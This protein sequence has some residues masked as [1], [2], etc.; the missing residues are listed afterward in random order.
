LSQVLF[1]PSTSLL[2]FGIKHFSLFGF[3]HFYSVVGAYALKIFSPMFRLWFSL[4]D[5]A[6]LCFDVDDDEDTVECIIGF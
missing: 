6:S 3:S 4:F 5:F 1:G 2:G